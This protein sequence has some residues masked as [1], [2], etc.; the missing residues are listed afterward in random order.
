MIA[1][2]G[3]DAKGPRDLEDGSASTELAACMWPAELDAPV[4]PGA[5]H[6]ART[7]LRCELPGGVTTTC[8]SDGVTGCSGLDG[9]RVEVSACTLECDAGEYAVSC[10]AVGA[11]DIQDPPAGCRDVGALPAGF[12]LYCCP[13][14]AR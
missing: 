1:A 9:S 2:C 14:E 3:D 10:G 7:R 4:E 13:C 6:A 11:S 5:C 8:E 12:T